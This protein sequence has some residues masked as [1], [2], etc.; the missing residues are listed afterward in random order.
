MAWSLTAY[1]DA[2]H[3]AYEKF[4][5][6]TALSIISQTL[7]QL[8]MVASRVFAI[9]LFATVFQGIVMIPLG[10]LSLKDYTLGHP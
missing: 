3:I 10:E 6:R 4:Y 1:T 9:V 7:W 5:K 2:L 8:G